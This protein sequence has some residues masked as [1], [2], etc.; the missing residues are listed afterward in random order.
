MEP[1]SAWDHLTLRGQIS[2]FRDSNSQTL[3]LQEHCLLLPLRRLLVSLMMGIFP[4][5]QQRLFPLFPFGVTKWTGLKCAICFSRR[6][7]SWFAFAEIAWPPTREWQGCPW[8]FSH[9]GAS[10]PHL[11]SH[12]ISCGF[13][14][15]S[16]DP[17]HGDDLRHTQPLVMPDIYGPIGRRASSVQPQTGHIHTLTKR[18]TKTIPAAGKPCHPLLHRWVGKGRQKLFGLKE[19]LS[20][21]W[22]RT[23]TA[24]HGKDHF[25]QL[26][27]RQQEQEHSKPKCPL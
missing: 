15:L 10:W 12:N 23:Q 7:M 26:L 8:R 2:T 20:L 3:G 17:E 4:D 27:A 19:H 18:D 6:E 5:F 22:E 14:R 9:K 1:G 11:A 21:Q 13:L 16:A 25:C 24:L